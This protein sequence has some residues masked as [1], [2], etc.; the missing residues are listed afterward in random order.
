MDEQIIK[1]Y[2]PPKIEDHGDLTELTAHN[3]TG[4]FT[5]AAFPAGTPQGQLTFGPNSTP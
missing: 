2:E 5:D 4:P 1:Q 3:G